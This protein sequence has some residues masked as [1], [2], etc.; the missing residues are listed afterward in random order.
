MARMIRGGNLGWARITF[1][2]GEGTR[3]HAL[4]SSQW[5]TDKRAEMVAEAIKENISVPSPPS[6][7][8]HEFPHMLSGE[9]HQS[10]QTESCGMGV[11][12]VLSDARHAL[13]LERGSR[14]KEPRPFFVPTLLK[15]RRW[16]SRIRLY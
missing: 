13:E 12:R 14:K 6:S 2:N 15:L 11:S 3:K 7:M 1:W 4:R 8:P 9:L 10:I 5:A 16:F